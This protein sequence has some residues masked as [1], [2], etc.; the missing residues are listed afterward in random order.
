MRTRLLFAF[1]FLSALCSS[2][3]LAQ[4]P[5]RFAEELK[6]YIEEDPVAH[7]GDLIVFTGSSSI[8]MWSSLEDDMAGYHVINRGFGGSQM[9]DLLHYTDDLVV[10]HKPATVCVYEGDNDLE[11]GKN[12]LGIINDFMSFIGKMNAELPDVQLVFISPKPSIARWEL[13]D[14]YMYLNKALSAALEHFDNCY[15]VDVWTPMFDSEGYL[16]QDLFIEDGL[17]M[18]DKGYEIWTTEVRKVLDSIE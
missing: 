8:R 5:T 10:K 16:R 1:L 11:A 9:S 13:R 18:N 2:A 17:H 6:P 12:V 15:F 3:L 7:K 14:N 4:D